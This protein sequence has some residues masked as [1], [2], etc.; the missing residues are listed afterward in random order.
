G[1]N[2]RQTFLSRLHMAPFDRLLLSS[3]GKRLGRVYR[4]VEWI[5]VGPPVVTR[6][7]MFDRATLAMSKF[8]KLLRG[9]L[10]A[11]SAHYRSKA[12]VLQECCQNYSLILFLNI[13]CC[14]FARE[15]IDC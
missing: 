5:R 4:G 14:K 12:N 1:Q 3:L 9:F 7:I 10:A 11:T 15:E 6:T 13:F 2:Y 8:V